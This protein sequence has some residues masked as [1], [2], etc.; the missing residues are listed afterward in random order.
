MT[1]TQAERVAA[2]LAKQGEL[3]SGQVGRV[4]EDLLRRTQK[5]RETVSRLVQ[6]EV[7]RQLGM[8]GIATRD[9]VARLQ[10]R[11]RALEQELARA[12]ATRAKAAGS[13]TSARPAT[14]AADKTTA[15]KPTAARS[16]AAKARTTARASGASTRS[17]A[18]GAARRSTGTGRPAGTRRS[19][20]AT[21]PTPAQGAGATKPTPAQGAE[22]AEGET[23]S[24]S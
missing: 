14:E 7:K 21:K 19:A 11:I 16:S 12:D 10:Q 8:L 5:N 22:A 23:S 17:S 6:R 24:E 9:E 2:R 18:T 15:A 4:A 20:G 3:Q 1:K 13:A